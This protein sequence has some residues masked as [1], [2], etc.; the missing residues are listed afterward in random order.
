MTKEECIRLV[1]EQ[2]ANLTKVLPQPDI[3]HESI[4]TSYIN[5]SDVVAAVVPEL[6]NIEPINVVLEVPEVSDDDVRSNNISASD[7]TQIFEFK[8]PEAPVNTTVSVNRRRT[9]NTSTVSTN[10]RR[11]IRILQN[12]EKRKSVAP[13]LPSPPPPPKRRRTT[14]SKKNDRQSIIGNAS[15]VSKA[16]HCKKVLDLLNKGDLKEIQVLAQIGM[17]TAYCIITHRYRN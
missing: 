1:E 7:N 13:K 16:D 3:T 14:I 2:F 11:S 4:D 6:D 5:D 12:V 8:V 9:V 17:K 10:R 15:T